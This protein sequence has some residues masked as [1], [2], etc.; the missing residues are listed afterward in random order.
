[1]DP[2]PEKA[3]WMWR[4]RAGGALQWESAQDQ[5]LVPAPLPPVCLT[6]GE[7]LPLVLRLSVAIC[8][9]GS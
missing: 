4:G 5:G 3:S 1:M 6:L 7:P 9:W 8:K 2:R